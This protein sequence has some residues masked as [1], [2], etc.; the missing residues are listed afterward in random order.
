MRTTHVTTLT[1]YACLAAAVA[2]S[3]M[4][5]ETLNVPKGAASTPPDSIR[6]SGVIYDFRASHPDFD[7]VPAAGFGH[8]AGNVAGELT[9][10]GVPEF[11]GLGADA[12]A[13]LPPPAP[14]LEGPWGYDTAF[15]TTR[16]NVHNKQYAT[17]VNL[18]ARV[19]V[20]SISAY[21]GKQ[22]DDVR[23]AIYSDNAGEPGVLLAQSATKQSNNSSMA[24][25]TIAMNDV[26]LDAGDY[27][28]AVALD[29]SSQHHAYASSGGAT[30]VRNYDAVSNG[31]AASWGASS[32]TTT[33]KISIY[34]TVS[35]G[36]NIL[37]I[38]T[39]TIQT[40]P[41]SNVGNKQIATRV[42][43][44]EIGTL[45]SITAY[46]G[47]QDEDVRYAIY[48]DAGSDPG[49]LIAET[50][51]AE[52]SDD[53]GWLTLHVPDTPLVAAGVYWLAVALEDS[54]QA[55]QVATT[56][57]VTRYRSN[58]AVDN[59]FLSTW[60]TSSSST[61]ETISIYG[62]YTTETAAPTHNG[63][64][65]TTE[66][67]DADH[68]PIAPHLL[69]VGSDDAIGFVIDEQAVIPEDEFA[70]EVRV[71]GAAIQTGSSGYHMPVTMRVVV[72]GIAMEP[73]G[74]FD[75]PVLGNLN[76]DQS[77][78]CDS[79]GTNPR[80]AVLPG[81]FAAGDPVH[82]EARNWSL[83]GN[84]GCLA[85]NWEVAREVST[86]DDGVQLWVL[87]HGDPVPSVD[88][89]YE[90]ASAG[91]YIADYVNLATNTMVL[92]E[93]QVIYLFE[94]G[95]TGGSSSA[96]FQDLVV[97]VT[98]AS[99]SAGLCGATP[100]SGTTLCGEAF[101]DVAGVAVP[102]GE[103]DA[104]GG[105][106]SAETFAE[107]FSA[108]M[109][110]NV[111]LMHAITLTDDGTGVF[112]LVTDEF[113]PI[114]GRGFGNEGQPHNDHFTYMVP[115]SFTFEACAGQ[116]IEFEGDDDMWLF[117]DGALA[118][119]LG[120]VRPGTSQILEMDRL[121]L[122]DGADYDLVFFHARRQAGSARFNLRTNIP[123]RS[124]T[125]VTVSNPFD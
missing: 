85:S 5:P 40:T 6:L 75:D 68:R 43:M 27:W 7:V 110:T 17:R 104:S 67:K 101:A 2:G 49:A 66:W 12:Y 9:G 96:D 65:V 84:D 73:F 118:I 89:V 15:P 124:Q 16:G 78:T 121:G 97:L 33:E 34:A 53:M 38:G 19:V 93:S 14:V 82:V 90:Q 4:L 28:L 100:P 22:D 11:I 122:A 98:L 51:A 59:G 61:T 20:A 86:V 116:F 60:G 13:A 112:E 46:V 3:F 57:G 63:F 44:P 35:D 69:G 56:G 26:L 58:N 107:W 18:P 102:A 81:T 52:C 113:Y 125:V 24:W 77:V 80:C 54:D 42:T 103:L 83:N 108:V 10:A 119:D 117:V 62:I 8:Y 70:V 87:R 111:G 29:D 71:L 47:D 21:V 88:G 50:L 76:D 41:K 48:A 64:K 39:D 37:K 79:N 123:L 105:I 109:G 1:G 94:L 92:G 23:Y 25:L 32:G 114:D 99:D 30:R 72:D 74:A 95:T 115:A 31:Y 45:L 106:A 36:N 91:E 120:G 55:I